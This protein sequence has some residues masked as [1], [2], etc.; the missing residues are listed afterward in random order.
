MRGVKGAGTPYWD[1]FRREP[2]D[3]YAAE[4]G[5]GMT[6]WFR[7]ADRNN[8]PGDGVSVE[9]QMDDPAS[10][11]SFYRNLTRL[12]REAPA[13]RR[14]AFDLLRQNPLYVLRRWDEDALYIVAINFTREP[15]TLDDLTALR[16]IEGM[17]YD[18]DSLVVVTE[19]GVS[20]SADGPI[21]FAPA[22][23]AI[24]RMPRMP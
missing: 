19:Q 2:M 7:P 24:Y 17:Q 9:E 4:T 18:S 5:P 20:P 3:W 14:A 13:M 6:T 16:E 23:Y 1:E 10:L 8:V 11:L 22:G 21:T 15:L 12:R